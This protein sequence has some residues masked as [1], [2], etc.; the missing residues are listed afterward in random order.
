MSQIIIPLADENYLA[1][2]SDIA[3]RP[4]ESPDD[5]VYLIVDLER[6]ENAIRLLRREADRSALTTVIAKTEALRNL[7]FAENSDELDAEWSP[8]TVKES[9]TLG[10]R[11]LPSTWNE[12]SSGSDVGHDD[13]A[14]QCFVNS[15][16]DSGTL[17]S[18]RSKSRRVS[19]MHR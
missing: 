4:D 17:L 9:S 18:H 10:V 5:D 16:V 6:S 2:R 8:N 1:L 13:N 7:Q 3:G 12:D 14:I 11:W 15:R 19:E